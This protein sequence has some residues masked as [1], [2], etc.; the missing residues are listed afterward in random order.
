MNKLALGIVGSLLVAG[1]GALVLQHEA[2]SRLR[3]EIARLSRQSS[4]LDRLR[5]EHQRLAGLAMP[6]EELNR[7]RDDQQS[8]ARLRQQ[9]TILKLRVQT[10]DLARSAHEP[11]KP[12]APGMVPIDNLVD[13]G[14]GTPATAAQTF[15]W[16]VGQVD[17]DAMAKQLVLGAAARAKA[18]ALLAA[19]DPATRAKMGTPEKL[20]AYYFVGLLGRVAG[21]QMAGQEALGA[22]QAGWKVNLQMASG[23]MK[24]YS[25]SVRWLTD[26]WHEEVPAGL[27]DHWSMVLLRTVPKP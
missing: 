1:I 17:P 18:E 24:D 11:P 19:L 3:D 23:R 7:L 2:Q 20:M 8:L 6:P 22:D 5:R 25:L 13:A 21:I 26:G 12:L 27:V 4:Q 14:S 16:A 9:L 10:E 15:F